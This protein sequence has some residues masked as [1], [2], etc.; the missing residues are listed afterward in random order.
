MERAIPTNLKPKSPNLRD[1]NAS[2]LSPRPT[3]HQPDKS[4]PHHAMRPI[5]FR[6]LDHDSTSEHSTFHAHK[7]FNQGTN[8]DNIQKV[9]INSNSRVSPLLNLDTEHKHNQ[10]QGDIT[11][12]TRSFS[13]SASSSLGGYANANINN[14]K[15]H[16]F[17]VAT[18]T[19]PSSSSS[20]ASLNNKAGLLFHPQ[21]SAISVNPPQSPS[22]L[23]KKIRT[24]L[25]KPIW[26]LRRNCPCNDK[27]SVQ[28]KKNTPKPK[29]PAT[30]QTP[31]TQ[32][33]QILSSHKD[34]MNHKTPQTSNKE[35]NSQRLFQFQ[36]S[37]NQ[38]PRPLSEGFTFPLFLATNSTT[39]PQVLLNVVHEEEDTPSRDSLQV[40][41]PSSPPKS[42]AMDDD[43]ASDA[44]SDLFEIESF[45]TQTTTLPYP[46]T[47]S[48][49]ECHQTSETSAIH[50]FF[51]AADAGNNLWWRR[52]L[53]D[54]EM[55]PPPLQSQ[56]N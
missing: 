53:R 55:P 29:T 12:S 56:S 45:S 2:F 35:V 7:Y 33:P 26:L 14:Y 40:F 46:I 47:T 54:I 36:P 16:S 38:V 42:R 32:Q 1:R 34:S 28:V 3:P 31:P 4:E 49:A 21:T 48:I 25:S 44:S 39:K 52:R 51:F 37:M 5:G 22:D 41:Q 8:N 10:E 17:H 20:K 27:K 50:D 11:K 30:T 15:A 24:S 23:S 43:A 9:N 18:P 6:T 19:T 13:Y